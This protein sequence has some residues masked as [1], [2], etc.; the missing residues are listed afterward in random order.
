MTVV[1]ATKIILA[2]IDEVNAARPAADRIKPE[3]E[4]VLF[5]PE[6]TLD[7]LGLVEL[8]VTIEER[9]NREFG[10]GVSLASDQA[11]SQARSPF[12]T[13]RSL[14]EFLSRLSQEGNGE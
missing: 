13:V 11:L 5:G 7:S 6:G 2:S 1:E 8:I 3:V 14:S 12:H 10:V 9:A 4:T